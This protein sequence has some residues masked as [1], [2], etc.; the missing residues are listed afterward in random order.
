MIDGTGILDTEGTSHR[1]GA[2]HPLSKLS[3]K[4]LT[5]F[6]CV[7]DR[8]LKGRCSQAT[9]K[10]VRRLADK[11]GE[12][13]RNFQVTKRIRVTIFGPKVI[14]IDFRRLLKNW[15]HIYKRNG[16]LMGYTLDHMV[17][18]LHFGMIQLGNVGDK[19][20]D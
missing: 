6:S 20:D 4:D 1:S 12:D 9:G 7:H 2:D 5:P 19:H 16:L 14:R 8:Q 11:F 10:F 15:R 13:L 3:T 18:I 17:D